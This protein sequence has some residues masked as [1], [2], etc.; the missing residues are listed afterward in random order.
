MSFALK[1]GIVENDFIT[2]RIIRVNIDASL[3]LQIQLSNTIETKSV[4]Q[5]F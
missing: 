2:H 3:K 4:R 1:A 5:I